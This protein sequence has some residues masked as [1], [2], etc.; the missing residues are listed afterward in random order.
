MAKHRIHIVQ[1]GYN[2]YPTYSFKC[3]C[4]ARGWENPTRGQA[5]KKGTEHLAQAHGGGK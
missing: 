4:G 1:G 5:Q 3:S 2:G